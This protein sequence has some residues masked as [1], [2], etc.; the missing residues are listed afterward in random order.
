G[1]FRAAGVFVLHVLLAA[2][3]TWP[4][5][6]RAANHFYAPLDSWLN[7]YIHH[8]LYLYW[9]GDG[10]KPV[11]FLDGMMFYPARLSMGLTEWMAGNQPLFGAFHVLS[12]NPVLSYNLLLLSSLALNALCFYLFASAATGS[13]FAAF[14]GSM[15]FGF[16]PVVTGYLSHL[17]LLTCWWTPLCF[18][19]LYRFI[20]RKELCAL[21]VC[22]ACFVLQL[23]SSIHWGIFL[24][25][26][27]GLVFL[28]NGA[29]PAVLRMLRMRPSGAAVIFAA[30]LVCAGA[31]V[32]P[33]YA[34][35]QHHA[36]VREAAENIVYSA[37]VRS[38]FAVNQNNFLGSLHGL[39]EK[40]RSRDAA[41]EKHLYPGFAPLVLS[42]AGLSWFCFALVRSILRRIC[43]CAVPGGMRQRI[44][45]DMSLLL[46]LS[47]VF[48]LGPELVHGNEPTGVRLPYYFMLKYCPVF[49]ALRVPARW[50][51]LML[52]AAAVLSSLVIAEGERLLRR[53]G[54]SFG[55][56]IV[57][58]ALCGLLL[59]LIFA[60][61]INRPLPLDAAYFS[62][63]ENKLIS[64]LSVSALEGRAVLFWPSL[65]VDPASFE[66]RLRGSLENARRAAMCLYFRR[67]MVNG[68]SG[69]EPA[70][71][72]NLIRLGRTL[73]APE[74]IRRL[75]EA[76]VASVVFDKRDISA[77]HPMFWDD[78]LLVKVFE[79]ERYIAA[80]IR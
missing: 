60:E 39:L 79:N 15:V 30:A 35:H 4:L 50:S 71:A 44:M 13:C 41:W 59:L 58:I 40:N 55:S 68:Y 14:A 65:N 43:G 62:A 11:P 27:A 36:A 52:F 70:A 1:F 32:Y 12:E 76:G 47:F 51:L 23:A 16:A 67:P 25:T 49:G 33:Q 38:F 75:R 54:D 8:Y 31:L 37:E 46:I 22:L 24:L 56:R 6:V 78:V 2:A 61:Q 80:D 17:Q 26:G 9:T 48:A 63:E 64:A 3:V 7:T 72:W 28:L 45:R 57:R 53:F 10:I 74:Y 34:A 66:E 69:F 29:V 42:L 5:I 73:P 21:A 20:E 77:A 19:F 18:L